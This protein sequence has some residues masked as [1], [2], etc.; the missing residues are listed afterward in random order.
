MSYQIVIQPL[1]KGA[2]AQR[3]Q[4]SLSSLVPYMLMWF[5]ML[6]AMGYEIVCDEALCRWLIAHPKAGFVIHVTL[7]VVIKKG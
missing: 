2:C 7:E 5:Q 3:D 4:G 1:V 6:R